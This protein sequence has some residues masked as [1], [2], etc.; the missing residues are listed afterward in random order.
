MN[1]SESL[2]AANDCHDD[3]PARGAALL[4]GIDA[5]ALKADDWPLYAFLLNHVLIEKLGL[6]AEANERQHRLLAVAGE[7]PAPVLLRQAAV[8][9]LLA[10]D[11]VAELAHA[12]EFGAATSVSTA[13]A[14][15][16]VQLAAAALRVPGLGATAAGRL[17]L[18]ALAPLAAAHW[19]Q[20]SALDTAA[21]AQ[22]NNIA[23]SLA[24]RPLADLADATLR[25]AVER[26][27]DWSQV[28]WQRAGT[29][30]NHERAC[31]LRALVAGALGEAEAA[32]AHARAGLALLDTH[33][34]AQEQSVDRAFL[35]MEH[36]FAC[37]RLGR[38]EEAAAAHARADALE[39]D[40]NDA[41]LTAWYRQ[42]IE[43]NRLLKG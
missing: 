37:E 40:F 13:Q 39:A 42:R 43:R 10:G 25:E 5:A 20:T 23:G 6:P 16:L 2:N 4:R 22:C 12:A 14:V 19:Q 9:A 31:Y 11:S 15:E 1:A 34:D 32:R 26:T 21:A 38:A 24:E 17:A 33:D 30:V 3:D 28:F 36:A 27:A 7:T 41:G 35:E 18:D 29:W 8:S